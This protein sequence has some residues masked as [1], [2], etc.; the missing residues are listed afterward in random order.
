MSRLA[1]MMPVLVIVILGCLAFAFVGFTL[2]STNPNAPQHSQISAAF[3]YQIRASSHELPDV[4][5]ANT[6]R[7]PEQY[8]RALTKWRS[9]GIT[10]YEITVYVLS[11]GQSDLWTLRVSDSGKKVEVLNYAY[12]RPNGLDPL[13]A[14]PTKEQLTDE[15]LAGLTIEGMFA[16]AEAI[17]N[18]NL[19]TTEPITFTDAQ[20]K[21][22]ILTPV[23]NYSVSSDPTFGYPTEIGHTL[24]TEYALQQVTDFKVL[25]RT[26]TP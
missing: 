20:G 9:Q 11:L 23:T 10:D 19:A 18:R 13:P 22:S 6:I 1:K 3:P 5:Q 24:G 8:N 16:D 21:V 26:N 15:R 25:K 12:H 2:L 17:G 14:T 7:T 4:L